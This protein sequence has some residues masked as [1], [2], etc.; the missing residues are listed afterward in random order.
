LK[1]SLVGVLIGALALVVTSTATAPAAPFHPAGGHSAQDSPAAEAVQAPLSAA[2]AAARTRTARSFRP[3]TVT[4]LRTHPR[5]GRTNAPFFGGGA[6]SKKASPATADSPGS[7]TRTALSISTSTA[8]GP[9]VAVYNGLN[10]DGIK[11]S[12][13][14]TSETPPDS[15]GAIGPNDYVEMA[16]SMI[17][18]WD[19]NLNSVSSMSIDAFVADPGDPY[20]DPQIQWDQ[21]AGR[22][23]YSVLL[24]N[25][26]T[27]D[28]WI[29]FGWSKTSDP[30]NLV[31]GWC[32]SMGLLTTPY[33]FDYAKLGH[34]GQ[35]LILGGNFY[36]ETSA[37]NANPPFVGAALA[38][39]QLPSRTTTTCPSTFPTNH[40]SGPPL[41][42]PSGA[43]TFTPVPVNTDST[44]SNGYILSAYDPSGAAGNPAAPQ[45]DIASWHVDSSGVLHLD[46]DIP[47]NSYDTPPAAHQLG[48]GTLDTLLGQLT[49]AVGDPTTGLWTQHTVA[50]G[51]GAKVTW[52]EF[53]LN[54]TLGVLTKVQEG[55]VSS[56]TEDVYNAAISP[57]WSAGGAAIFYNRSSAT[58]SQVIAVRDRM[59]TTSLNTMDP[60]ELDLVTS[61]AADADL[62]CS[63]PYGPPCRWGDYAG[64]SPDPVN[65]SLVW[66]TGE[67]NAAGTSTPAW[68]DR[69]FAVP[70]WVAPGAPTNLT[71][72]YGGTDYECLSWTAPAS[73]G[74]APIS[75]YTIDAFDGSTPVRT[76]T[77]AAPSTQ[78]CVAGLPS[79]VLY[80]F[81]VAATNAAGVGPSTSVTAFVM[82]V[83]QA[84]TSAASPARTGATQASPA[85]SPPAR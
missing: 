47:V 36:D 54:S 32:T 34:T 28:Q 78:G 52:Y 16:N 6:R 27:S 62:S 80:T 22:W 73:N 7:P 10:K 21:A 24:C 68:Q 25:T 46:G 35:W 33:I 39:V 60:N 70:T 2:G 69:N 55:D 4:Q 44:A 64:A 85:P 74:G 66:G 84:S 9:H 50:G 30:S 14:T 12:D 82:R 57:S 11:A 61:S 53:K 65:Q 1:P 29:L 63:A 8:P 48:G 17:H 3:V 59:T 26:Q 38:W 72:R 76:V 71:A 31:S 83:T 79:E 15:T 45:S 20:C 75:K 81:V 49:Q 40:E 23:L 67:Y 56:A 18:V 43:W 42:D 13:N 77:I 58:T 37:P 5:L 41:T 19:R 51:A